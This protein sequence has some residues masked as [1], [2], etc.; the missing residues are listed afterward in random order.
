MYR[1]TLRIFSLVV[2]AV[3]VLLVAPGA[4]AQYDEEDILPK[5]GDVLIGTSFGGGTGA[6]YLDL[7]GLKS[8]NINLSL[9]YLLTDA[10][11]LGGNV[12]YTKVEAGGVSSDGVDWGIGLTYF[13]RPTSGNLL[14]YLGVGYTRME[15]W[16]DSSGFSIAGGFQSFLSP[17]VAI[18]FR[19]SYLRLKNG[20]TADGFGISLGLAFWLRK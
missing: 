4:Q 17:N 1:V 9:D 16:G 13:L 2:L 3:S 19:V 18:D 14:P 12:S 8:T 11:A 5:A 15:S 20:G 7:N 6:G 10:F